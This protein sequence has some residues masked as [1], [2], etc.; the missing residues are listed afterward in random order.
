MDRIITA[1]YRGNA[2]SADPDATIINGTPYDFGQT[3][4][5][6]DASGKSV[7]REDYVR[8]RGPDLDESVDGTESGQES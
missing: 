2:E 3:M 7:Y 6:L 4:A 8:D 5:G 1:G